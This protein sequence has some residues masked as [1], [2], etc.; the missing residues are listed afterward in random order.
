[1]RPLPRAGRG[2]GE[3]PRA[4]ARCGRRAAAARALAAAAALAAVA[5]APAG[6]HQRSQS[7]STWRVDG[8]HVRATFSLLAL[9]ATRLAAPTGRLDDLA[10]LATAH[11]R[12]RVAVRR[13]GARCALEA[14]QPL[15]A[16]PGHVRVELRWRCEGRGP[17]EAANGAFFDEAPSHVHFARVVVPGAPPREVLFRADARVQ[18]LDG[19]ARRGE[20]GGGAGFLGYL[21][22]GVEHIL[23][24]VDHLAFVGALL[25][26]GGTLR[27]LLF[28]ITG[29]TLGHSLTLSL[30]ALGF[31]R[32]DAALVEACIGYSIALVAAENLAVRAGV[33]AALARA[34]ALGLGA[35]AALAA[36]GWPRGAPAALPLAGLALFS[37][38]H[39]ELASA[40]GAARRLR[41]AVTALFG[42]VHGFGFAGVL[43]E[44][45]LPEGRLVQA[46]VGFN[47]GVELG[48]IAVVL[49]LLAV[50]ALARRAAPPRR[51]LA[52]DLASATL[53]ALGLFWFLVRAY[54]A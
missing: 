30:A 1:V 42:L 15:R 45:G 13:G 33:Q 47:A 39:L 40:P 8:A 19:G 14:A 32:V 20:A 16:R 28:V 17:L 48:Q 49:A 11:L 4:R 29:F 41:P 53:C 12:E 25:L 21:A 27:E 34:A 43:L 6:A 51:A 18:A 3:P 38:C 26:L 9:E 31:V 22:L 23:A 44:L 5:P 37:F 46:L 50:A 10:P 2:A 54:G 36:L 35:L 24:G 7:F 52:A